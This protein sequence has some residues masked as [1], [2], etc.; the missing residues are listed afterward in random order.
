M[1]LEIPVEDSETFT[2]EL[3][4]P[5]GRHVLGW[6]SP[7]PRGI[8]PLDG[9]RITRSLRRSLR[10]FDV[11]FDTDF[12]S[13]IRSCAEPD[14]DGGWID[15]GIIEAYVELHRLGWAHSVEVRDPSDGRILGGLYGVHVDGLFA[16]ESMFHRATDA[17]K[18]AL[19]A[20]V[21]R[22]RAIGV[23]LL[24]TQWLTPHL[25]SLGA[26]AIPRSEYLRRLRSA[27]SVPVGPFDP[28]VRP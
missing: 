28:G 8:V 15:E 9:M 18:V 17:S 13:V 1:P 14:R 16:G 4:R 7:D 12:D 3:L 22:L 11:T 10:R 19:V 5:G 2:D 21:D 26:I 27:S 6:W 24:D 23:V 25:A 20:L